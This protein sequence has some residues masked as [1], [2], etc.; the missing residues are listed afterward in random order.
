MGVDMDAP[1]RKSRYVEA[2]TCQIDGCNR[3]YSCKGLCTLHYNRLRVSGEIGPPG[4]KKRTNG[5]VWKDPRSGYLYQHAKLHHRVVMEAIIGRRL[6]P[7]EQVHHRNGLR[8]D[9]R[10]ENLELWVKWQPAGQR[11]DDLVAFVVT[12]YPEAVRAA[13]NDQGQLTLA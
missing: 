1:F 5:T 12:H 7:F 3:T 4:V 8:D 2:R 11:V 13:L 10:P 6:E 9:N